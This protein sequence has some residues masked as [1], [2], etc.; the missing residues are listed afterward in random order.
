MWLIETR[1][2]VLNAFRQSEELNDKQVGS[3]LRKKKVLNAF[4]QSE[5]LNHCF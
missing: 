2:Q 3:R 1:H 5:E 4:R